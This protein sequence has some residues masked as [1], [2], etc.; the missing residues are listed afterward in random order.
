MRHGF[1][2]QVTVDKVKALAKLK[3][4]REQH[5][6]LVEEARAGYRAKALA[7]LQ[8]RTAKI[9]EGKTVSLSFQLPLPQDFTREYDMAI[10]MLEAHEDGVVVLKPDEF[11]RLMLDEWDWM[12]AFAGVNAAYSDGTRAWGLEKGVEVEGA[13]G[14]DF[15][16]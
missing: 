8:Q 2:F 1:D 5:A 6:R 16:R 4:N 3:E 14:A 11:R 13:V 15:L 10:A 9:R 12:N 7:A